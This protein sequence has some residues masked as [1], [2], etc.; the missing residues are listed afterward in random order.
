MSS[1]YDGRFA[2]GR[3]RCFPEAES[4]RVRALAFEA[5]YNDSQWLVNA[6]TSLVTDEQIGVAQG[7]FC[8]ARAGG[9]CRQ[10]V[11]LHARYIKDRVTVALTRWVSPLFS[12]HLTSLKASLAI[13]TRET[14]TLGSSNVWQ[15]SA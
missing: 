14:R 11:T 9:I 15:E 5:V 10:G 12:S 7:R 4:A 8:N 13:S 1:K 3:I 2:N 6:K